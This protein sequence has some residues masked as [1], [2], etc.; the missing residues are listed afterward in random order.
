MEQACVEVQEA[1]LAWR[2]SRLRWLQ[3]YEEALLTAGARAQRAAEEQAALMDWAV[4]GHEGGLWSFLAGERPLF[5]G[6]FRWKLR[7]NGW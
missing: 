3:S 7:V 6:R 2:R 1:Q 5:K 4:K